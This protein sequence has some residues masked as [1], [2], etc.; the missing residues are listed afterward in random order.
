VRKI[1]VYILYAFLIAGCVTP[2]SAS[3]FGLTFSDQAARALIDMDCNGVRDIYQGVAVCEEKSPRLA[4][5][6]VKIPPTPGRVIFSDGLSKKVVDFN[7]RKD[8]FLWW[9]R[10]Q[11]DRP[12]VPLDIGELSATF[13]EVPV[14]FDVAGELDG[15]G[16][17]V[18]RGLVY[19]RICN[20]RDIP[21]SR[22][23]VDYEC[24]GRVKNTGDGQLG[25]CNRMSG[26]MARF[27]VPLKTLSYQLV[28]GAKIQARAGRSAWTIDHTVTDKDVQAGEFKF[29]YPQVFNGP[30]LFTVA[31]Y[32]REQGVPQRYRTNILIVGYDPRWTGIDN[33]HWL[34][35]KGNI[36]FCIPMQSELLQI[37][38]MGSAQSSSKA[39]ASMPAS[40]QVCAFAWDRESGDLTYTCVK[41][42]KEV[43]WGGT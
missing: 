13:G 12:W 34:E 38:D 40:G 22:L 39:C 5:V 19:H 15:V 6:R 43:R 31:V 35:Q 29:T 27:R 4:D 3:I 18:T 28:A 21:C 25:S 26:S 37:T 1:S 2:R 14:A 30:D 17:I 9:K 24:S 10:I 36:E 23:V 11:L 20:D 7:W 16:L 41:N 32:Q 42:G 8:G 33:P